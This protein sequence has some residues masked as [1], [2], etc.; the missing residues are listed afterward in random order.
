MGMGSGGYGYESQVCDLSI[1]Q[2]THHNLMGYLISTYVL[3]P[4]IHKTVQFQSSELMHTQTQQKWKKKK[5]NTLMPASCKSDGSTKGST[6]I[7]GALKQKALKV[8]KAILPKKK[9]KGLTDDDTTSIASTLPGTPTQT[10]DNGPSKASTIVDSN[11]P[12]IIN[13]ESDTGDEDADAELDTLSLYWCCEK[14]SY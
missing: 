2:P 11:E 1:C 10:C 7:T 5:T 6:N 8:I 9:R 12:T 14:N 3:A 13:I 4:Q